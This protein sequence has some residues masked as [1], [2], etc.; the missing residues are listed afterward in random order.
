MAGAHPDYVYFDRDDA[1]LTE[2]ARRTLDSIAAN[3]HAYRRGGGTDDVSYL[4]LAYSDRSEAEADDL[5][6]S[7]RRA[8]AIRQHLIGNGL[9]REAIN[10]MLAGPSCPQPFENHRESE[11][12]NRRVMIWATWREA[13]R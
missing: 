9:P 6:L 10:T 7:R 11:A 12:D 8:G 5:P 2:R 13:V 4:L 3:W 1:S